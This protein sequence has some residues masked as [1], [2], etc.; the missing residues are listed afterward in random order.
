M[1]DRVAKDTWVEI[2]QIA[3]GAEDRA[4]QVPVDTR[5]LPLEMRIKGF[6][7]AAVRVGEQAEIVTPAGRRLRG[8][9]SVVNPAYD[10]GF[11]P[12]IP[13]LSTIGAHVRGMLRERGRY[14]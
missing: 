1:T 5:Q 8:V 13:E 2:H 14:Q 11:G 4:P 6:L 7:T 3:L 9:L 12:A 10:H